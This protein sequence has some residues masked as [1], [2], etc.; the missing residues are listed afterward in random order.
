ML[1]YR[2]EKLQEIIEDAKDLLP[3]IKSDVDSYSQ[4]LFDLC[5][6]VFYRLMETDITLECLEADEELVKA[7]A[8]KAKIEFENATT[9]PLRLTITCNL[10][11]EL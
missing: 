6:E 9:V 5:L 3:S 8:D 11:P 4:L 10:K 2:D 7:A 1:E